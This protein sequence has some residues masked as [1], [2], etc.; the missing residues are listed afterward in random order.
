MPIIVNDSDCCG[1]RIE[2]QSPGGL[3]LPSRYCVLP[4]DHPGPHTDGHA[5][6]INLHRIINNV[7]KGKPRD[8]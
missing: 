8:A 5:V 3:E 6:W 7:N 2:L 4:K 1:N